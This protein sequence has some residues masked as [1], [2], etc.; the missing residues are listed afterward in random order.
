MD[1]GVL[2]H[3]GGE[4]A[5]S[6][7]P[8]Q[9]PGARARYDEPG[10][11]HLAVSERSGVLED[12]GPGATGDAGGDPLDPDEARGPV[13]TQHLEEV[14]DAR[15]GDIS[16]ERLL[17]VD[18]DERGALARLVV[19]RRYVGSYLDGAGRARGRLHDSPLVR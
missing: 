11:G 14:H 7:Q 12:E 1:R 8:G 4:P 5:L 9:V 10:S 18:A 2:S 19:G 17:D 3:G 13:R 15:A 16:G 6:A